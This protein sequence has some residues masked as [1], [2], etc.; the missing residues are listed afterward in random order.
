MSNI[1]DVAS[2]RIHDVY[3]VQ[4]AA[5]ADLYDAILEF[6]QRENIR[7]GLVLNIV[8]GLRKVR[9]S[10]PAAKASIESQPGILD[11]E[12]NFECAGIGYIGRT[13][14]TYDAEKTS[15]ILYRQDEPNL[16][17]HLTVSNSGATHMGHLIPGCTV[18]SVATVSHFTI[19]IARVEGVVLNMRRS[20]E[21]TDK[22]RLGIPIHELVK[23]V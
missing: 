8:G 5:G 23:A 18:R 2:S 7:T 20:H 6:A 15:G 17:I 21:T 3:W 14:D 11:I 10:T 19:C 1:H 16:H 13:V 22:Y 4:L 9:L 12:G